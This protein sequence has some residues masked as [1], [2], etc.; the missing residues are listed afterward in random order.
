MTSNQVKALLEEHGARA[1]PGHIE[2]AAK[3]VSGLLRDTAQGFASLP[4]EVEPSG[5]QAEQRRAVP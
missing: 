5:F 4:L 2:A 1:A 3:I